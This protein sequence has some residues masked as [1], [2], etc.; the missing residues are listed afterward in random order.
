MTYDFFSTRG[1]YVTYP[2]DLE[3]H[4]H[5]LMDS[6]VPPVVVYTKLV[7]VY[8]SL[9]TILIHGKFN[10]GHQIIGQHITLMLIWKL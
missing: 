1:D 8:T 4:G 3:R 6:N 2:E 9:A 5:Y 7:V 10:K